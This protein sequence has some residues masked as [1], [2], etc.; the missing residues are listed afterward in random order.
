MCSTSKGFSHT[1]TILGVITHVFDRF[2]TKLNPKV[3]IFSGIKTQ[4][5]CRSGLAGHFRTVLVLAK[6]TFHP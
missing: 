6:V 3:N 5:R 4:A 1:E 2:S